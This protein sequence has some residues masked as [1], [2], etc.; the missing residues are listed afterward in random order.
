MRPLAGA[1]GRMSVSTF[2]NKGKMPLAL[3]NACGFLGAPALYSASLPG[4]SANGLAV[5]AQGQAPETPVGV[6]ARAG[7]GDGLG[8]V[9]RVV[10]GQ[11]H[12]PGFF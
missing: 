6:S 9:R 8:S 4:C 2:P 1:G 7:P 11:G 3:R 12:L 5:L 10:E